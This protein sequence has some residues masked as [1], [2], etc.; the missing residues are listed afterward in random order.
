M[1]GEKLQEIDLKTAHFYILADFIED[2]MCKTN[3]LDWLD[4]NPDPYSVFITGQKTDEKRDK[5]KGAFQ[6]TLR[7]QRERMNR[8]AKSIFNF[9]YVSFPW[10][11]DFLKRTGERKDTTMQRMLQRVESSIMVSAHEDAAFPSSTRHDSI[12]VTKG[13]EEMAMN[14]ILTHA[15]ERL[16]YTIPFKHPL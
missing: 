14:L 15:F 9:F 13:D 5:M 10:L 16:G 7:G 8:R 4:S 11:Y 1:G 6:Q 12:L 3:Y 2:E